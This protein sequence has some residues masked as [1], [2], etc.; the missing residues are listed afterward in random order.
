M[1]VLHKIL[2]NPQAMTGLILILLLGMAALCAPLLAPH[3]PAVLSPNLKYQLPSPEYPLGTDQ[4]GRCELSRLLYGARASLGLALPALL[5]LGGIGLLIGTVTSCVGGVL[6]RIVTA[7]CQIFIAF[8]T[9]IIAA[10]I[11][12]ILGNGLQNIVWAVVIS[13]WARF[14]Q[15]VRTY[16]LTE[17]GR[18]YITAAHVSGC[19]LPGL[20]FRHI[21][22]NILPQ[23]LVYFSTGVASAI[24]TVSSFS[25][26]GLGL[27]SGTAEWGAMLSEAQR[28]LY[29][30][31]ELL[32]YPGLCILI[33][34]AG[35]NLFGE[36]LRDILQPE[37][38]AL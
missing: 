19:G 15:L 37:E 20:I 34:A 17:L 23:F 33:A 9:L 2:K 14:T 4:L 29:S 6:D 13:M 21:L 24:L 36:A 28:G 38:N 35:F 3:D 26:L 12:G 22:P 31:P 18:D 30:H 25:F 32:I 11:I 7:V 5:L 10:A 16:T 27:P 8:P 1:S